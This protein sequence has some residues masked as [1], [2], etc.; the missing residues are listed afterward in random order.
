MTGFDVGQREEDLKRLQGLRLIDDDFMTA[1]LDGYAE[2]A[3]LILNVILDRE[4]LV[5]SEVRTQKA[6]KNLQG[7]D[8]W[9]DIY[10]TDSSGAKYDIEVQRSDKGAD[11]KRAR[12]H[13]SMMDA[14]MLKSGDDYSELHES[15][16]IFITEN[17][18]MGDGLPVY[19]I[20]RGIVEEGNLPFDDGE[21]II[22]VNASLR[23]SDTALGRLMSDFY[24]TNAADMNYSELAEKVRFFKEKEEGVE[25]MCR[26]MDE[27]RDETALKTRI[28]N[29]ARM[30][31]SGKLS[32]E[33][34]AL[35]SGLPIEKV[36][37]LAGEK[38][39]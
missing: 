37:E 38:T 32:L 16:V 15:Y 13:S 31:A 4:D 28:E 27:L 20:E 18:V 14:D 9:L 35:F 17:D 8:V 23:P 26:A 7:R 5:V 10:A 36:R 12:Y 39:A 33:D 22:Y 34:I 21:H 11:R 25:S 1:C 19:H 6:M 3:Q 29:A 30:I 2:G 24:C